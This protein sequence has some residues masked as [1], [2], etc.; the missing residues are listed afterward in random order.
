VQRRLFNIHPLLIK[1][2]LVFFDGEVRPVD[3]SEHWAGN[4]HI[5]DFSGVLLHYKLLGSLYGLARQEVEERRYVNRHGKYDK[6]RKV[7]DASPELLIKRDTSRELESVN[8]LIGTQLAVVSKEYV[9]FIG[10]ESQ[11]SEDYSRDGELDRIY[12]IFLRRKAETKVQ[13]ISSEPPRRENVQLQRLRQ[14]NAQ[15]QRLRQENARLRQ[16]ME[17]MQNGIEWLER[18]SG[19]FETRQRNLEIQML[20]VQSSRSWRLMD[21]LNRLLLQTL[22]EGYKRILAL[23]RR[24]R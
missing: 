4:A 23:S 20:G 13:S 22:G 11:K 2:P 3:F 14:E 12:E 17:E 9:R 8:D 18:R 7:L 1:H 16:R 6:Y 24:G 19:W 5:A 10:K 15:L 21:R